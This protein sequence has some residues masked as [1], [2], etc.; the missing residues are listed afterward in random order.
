MNFKQFHEYIWSLTRLQKAIILCIFDFFALFISIWMAYSL[1]FSILWPLTYVF[2]NYIVFFFT[3]LLGIV[4]FIR[5]GLYRAVVRFMNIEILKSI[6]YGI[7]LTILGLYSASYLFVDI[8]IPRSVPIIFGLVACVYLSLSRFFIK[9]YYS[10]LNL[11]STKSNK[12]II[13]GAGA[14]GTQLLISLQ[15]SVRYR[16]VAV[17]DDDAKKQGTTLHGVPVLALEK[18]DSFI[19]KSSVQA[20]FIAINNISR[21]AKIELLKQISLFNVQVKSIPSLDGVISGEVIQNLE[22]ISIDRVLG[23]DTIKANKNLTSLSIKGKSI[24]ITGAGGSIGSELARQSVRNGARLIVLFESNEHA[25]YSI[26]TEL[27]KFDEVKDNS[28]EIFSI[29]GS[30]LDERRV[31][32]TFLKFNVKIVLHAAAFKHVPIVE[33]NILQGLS[34]NS[35][36]TFVVANVAENCGIERFI[37]ISTDKAVRPTNIMGATKRFAELIIQA[38][39]TKSDTSTIFSMVRFGNVLGSSGSVIPL[40]EEQIRSGGPVTVTH[41][42]ITRYFMTISEAASLVLQANSLANGGEVFVL[43]MGSPM[44]IK[45]LAEMMIRLSGRKVKDKKDKNGDI[46]IIYTGLRPGEKLFEE[47]LINKSAI[48][49]EH[50]MIMMAHE[51]FL[52]EKKLIKL[53]KLAERALREHDAALARNILKE[54]VPEYSPSSE[55]ID[56]LL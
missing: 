25:L 15:N 52:S 53:I 39:S 50:P 27:Q 26:D 9:G 24:C 38:L 35:L 31:K 3:P 20:I 23:R 33:K 36:G 40:F 2:D 41:P 37:L 49:T 30:V 19:K 55:N 6:G 48:G 10:W 14:F 45:Q 22:P 12:V 44:K 16:V 47:I 13:Y 1:R 5:L 43:D 54:A 8:Q 42:D 56:L 34:N 51:N 7:L 11:K 21:E 4:L 46:E 17:V 18:L 28:C 29:L 32:E